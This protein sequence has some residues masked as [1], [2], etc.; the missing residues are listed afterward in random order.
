MKKMMMLTSMIVL[1]VFLMP[2][3]IKAQLLIKNSAQSELMRVTQSGCIG[4]GMQSPTSKLHIYGGSLTTMPYAYGVPRPANFYTSLLAHSTTAAQNQDWVAIDAVL[5]AL[6][7]DND[8]IHI[9]VHG[10][11]LAGTP[12]DNSV[13]GSLGYSNMY[14]ISKI[15]A[16]VMGHVRQSPV[17]SLPTTAAY[18]LQ[19]LNGDDHYGMIV[20]GNALFSAGYSGGSTNF[21]G[22]L[23]LGEDKRAS[24]A[25]F[26]TT[27]TLYYSNHTGNMV[28]QAQTED[29]GTKYDIDL[30]C[31]NIRMNGT[32]V[33]ASDE[34]WKKEITPLDTSVDELL[35]LESRQF[36]WIDERDE[37]THYGLI[38]QEVEQ[39]FPDLVVADESGFKYVN[40]LEL[41]PLML[42][43][44]QEQQR[45]ITE[46]Q[47]K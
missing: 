35:S 20:R 30:K 4:I 47:R 2:D 43:A 32:V 9:A 39:V 41:I 8:Y 31:A 34:R 46:L 25:R 27:S 15:T 21:D 24:I 3:A 10:T 7:T 44:I 42:K 38:A 36:K 45:Q 11:L 40:Y 5:P 16:G 19:D 14:G 23:F 28:F 37:K 33:H 29:A 22:V 17:T 12:A 13:S 18:F 6:T 26:T 1:Q